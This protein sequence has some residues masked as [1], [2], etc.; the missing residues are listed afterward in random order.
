MVCIFTSKCPAGVKRSLKLNQV[1]GNTDS[2]HSVWLKKGTWGW[3][4]GSA[5][6]IVATVLPEDGVQFLV[7][8]YITYIM[9]YLYTGIYN[10]SLL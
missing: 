2:L 1:E 7:P 9:Y 10:H 4:D 3:R 8:Y 5:V 6:K